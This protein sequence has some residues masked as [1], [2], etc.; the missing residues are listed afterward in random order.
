[1]SYIGSNIKKIRKLK[2]L[3]QAD[4]AQLFNLARPSVGAYEEGR[5]EPKID[6]IVEISNIFGIS[7]D[8]LLKKELTVNDLFKI[9]SFN[10]KM[11]QAHVK[12]GKGRK[13][14][15]HIIQHDQYSDY[16]ININNKD[17]I[18]SKTE[19][20][21]IPKITEAKGVLRVF[22]MNHHY[23]SQNNEGLRAGDYLLC[24][25]T[26]N[27]VEERVYLIV[28]N[29][30]I[31][32]ARL[33]KLAETS[34]ELAPDNNHYPPFTIDKNQITEAWEVLGAYTSHLPKPSQINLRLSDLEAQLKHL[35]DQVRK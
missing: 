10:K 16:I 20:I 34:L 26:S 4:F 13:I 28:I 8:L 2:K 23:M 25:L 31:K 14:E 30:E 7:I 35:T 15:L 18:T 21:T 11:D 33:I 6:T 22:E 5:S 32:I 9:E 3:S 27:F 1:M 17:F 19:S 12:K 29:N 24:V